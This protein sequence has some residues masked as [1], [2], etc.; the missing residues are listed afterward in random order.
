VYWDE[1]EL[2]GPAE[3]QAIACPDWEWADLDGDRLVWA[4]K[5][6]LFA[7][8][9]AMNGLNDMVELHDFNAMQFEAIEA[10]Y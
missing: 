6:K 2:V 1:H 5:G 3:S 8:S 10:P 9:V 7:A 4:A